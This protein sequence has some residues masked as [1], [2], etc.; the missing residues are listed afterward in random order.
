M[1]EPVN[2]P[3]FARD[4]KHESLPLIVLGA[5]A[6]L[7]TL[8]EYLFL[9]GAFVRWFPGLADQ[10]APG[11]TNGE[12]AAGMQAPWWGVLAPWVWWVLGQFALWV[13]APAV[14]AKL[15]G[16]R[17][18]DLGLSAKGLL[19]KLWIYGVLYAIVMLG[20]LWASTRE[21]FTQQYPMIK[22]WYCETW[23]WAVLLSF[24]ALYAAQFFAVEFFFRGW[25]LFTLE[26]RM[27]MS[28]VAVMIVPYCMI[29]YH[30]PLPEAL[31]AIVAGLVLGWMALRTRSIWGGWMV[32]VAI[33]ISMDVMSL[34]KG[35][36]G[37]PSS[38]GP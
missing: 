8:N 22:P 15:S 28:A 38:F 23:C 13:I 33:A 18:R 2:L 34:L 10:L 27:G 37:L 11:V 7:L 31:G 30:K 36:Y 17:L 29:H 26:K 21:S 20:V 12:W 1:Q 19:P 6:V 35:N 9:P 5:A 3:S 16:F 32:H 14:I 24:W 25:M 4:M